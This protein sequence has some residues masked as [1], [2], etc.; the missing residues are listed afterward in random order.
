MNYRNLI[1]SC[2]YTSLM[3][4][5]STNIEVV[6]RDFTVLVGFVQMSEGGLKGGGVIQQGDAHI[7]G[8]VDTGNVG[9]EFGR[10]W[11][12]SFDAV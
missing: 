11:G 1:V 10:F 2:S 5:G 3:L 9:L 12:E 6:G 8:T 4:G 7:E